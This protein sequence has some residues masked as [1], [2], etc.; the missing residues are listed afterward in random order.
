MKLLINN[1]EYQI[2]WEY[3]FNKQQLLLKKHKMSAQRN[4][5]SFKKELEKS[6][7]LTFCILEKK[8]KS[9]EENK[10]PTESEVLRVSVTRY[11]DQ[12]FDKREA[13]Y[14]SFIKLA[15]NLSQCG[16]SKKDS[17]TLKSLYTYGL[18]NTILTFSIP[19]WQ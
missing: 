7:D 2:T 9:T 14:E 10:F 6:K 4:P 19:N 12:K 16:W 5:K 17:D 13:R 15:N 18:M 3:H 1:E 11:Y 8:I